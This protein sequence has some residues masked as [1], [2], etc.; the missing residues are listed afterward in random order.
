MK[1]AF[2][3]NISFSMKNISVPWN[4][5]VGY[6]VDPAGVKEMRDNALTTILPDGLKGHRFLVLSAGQKYDL[7]SL[8]THWYVELLDAEG[9]VISML[10]VKPVEENEIIAYFSKVSL[11]EQ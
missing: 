7:D 9:T 2:P 8:K 11:A 5:P 1:K 4:L 3:K 10:S 6:F